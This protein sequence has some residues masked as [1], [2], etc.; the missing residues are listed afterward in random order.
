LLVIFIL[1]QP[2]NYEVTAYILKISKVTVYCTDYLNSFH[3]YDEGNL[4][5]LVKF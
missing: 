3:A 1:I 2:V 4:S 5:W